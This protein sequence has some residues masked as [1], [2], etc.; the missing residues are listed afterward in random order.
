[1]Y[2]LSF[3]DGLRFGCGLVFALFVSLIV[4]AILAVV[5]LV[6]YILATGQT[7][8][9]EGLLSTLCTVLPGVCQPQP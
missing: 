5:A 9:M 1:M 3:G 2:G 4:L 8:S 6:V 7:I